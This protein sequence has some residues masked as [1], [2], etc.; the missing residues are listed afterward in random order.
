M[1]PSNS[2]ESQ[3]FVNAN[4]LEQTETITCMSCDSYNAAVKGNIDFF[5][6]IT[7]QSLDL[8]RT[9]N[10]NTILHIYIT[11]LNPG[12]KSTTTL[13]TEAESTTNF[14]K[15]I[16]DMCPSLL[17]QANAKGETPLH[18]AARYGHSDIVEVLIKYCAQTR[19]DQD[20]EEGIEPVKEML[21]MT[22][23]EKDT[24]LHEAVRYNHLEVVKLLIGEDPNFSYS[25]N[26]VGE[27]PLYLAAE[28][29]FVD[30]L[31]QILHKC[32]SPMHGGPL[33]RT[34]LHAAV[35]R[36]AI[37]GYD[38]T[39]RL[40]EKIDGISRK[41]D[42]NGWTPLHL[43]VCVPFSSSKIKWLLAKDREVAYMKDTEGQTPLHIAAR[44][45]NV[46]AMKVIIK[47]CPDCC[48]LVD[49]RG[50]NVLHFAIKREGYFLEKIMDIII[51]NWSFS[52]LLNEKNADGDTPL[53]F[54]STSS[55]SVKLKKFVRHPRVDK[56]AFNKQHLNALQI[57]S[58]STTGTKVSE[59]E[60]ALGAFPTH[61]VIT[62]KVAI[63]KREDMM[64]KGGKAKMER[65]KREWKKKIKKV[66]ED[67]LHEAKKVH[68]VVAALI[69]TVTFA[70]CITMPGGFVN[71]GEGL[72][73]GSVLLRRK[74]V[75]KA[76]VIIDTI[77][78]VLSSL[79]VFIHLLMPFLYIN[80]PMKLVFLAFKFILWAMIAMVLAFV[81][82]T[83]AVLMPSLNLAIANCIIGLT[84]FAI[85][86]LLCVFQKFL[87]I[88][89]YVIFRLLC[90]WKL[91]V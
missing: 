19:H 58:A 6:A 41:V 86:L 85:L 65:E 70:A 31:V 4:Q 84:F 69:A 42:S 27:T 21:R 67:Q 23:K 47:R 88:N 5:K 2:F 91:Y 48:E 37:D 18:I 55:E 54:C 14:V 80:N 17:Q 66:T 90:P 20:L 3:A 12:S 11:A 59:F 26:D 7:N 29:G 61:R 56:M 82:G 62:F 44:S 40:P 87:E 77:S 1:D 83:Y 45:G 36:V 64:K 74:A 35:L 9:P 75:F 81:T 76:F 73:P 25:A 38:M 50:W 8:L 24:A 30:V 72:H 22:N 57:A 28:K 32:K 71:G 60:D 49:N 33:G 43:A 78:M 79:A 13:N 39:T 68:L 15:E 10:K 63:T 89:L 46:Q 34:A 51:E 53:H 16:L 52:N